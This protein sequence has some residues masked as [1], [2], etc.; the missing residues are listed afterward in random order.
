LF[1]VEEGQ[2]FV[3]L[4]DASAVLALGE[5][6]LHTANQ[7][8][9][10]FCTSIAQRMIEVGV[11]EV[12]RQAHWL[13][14]LQQMSRPAESADRNQLLALATGSLLSIVP[15]FSVDAV[16]TT[17]I[18][19]IARTVGHGSLEDEGLA[20]ARERARRNPDVPSMAA[21]LAHVRGLIN[22]DSREFA[23]AA[24]GFASVARPLAQASALE[25]LGRAL[26]LQGH[27]TDGVEQ[28]SRSLQTYSDC[29]ATWDAGR[30]RGRLRA[31][32]VR[33]RLARPA[34]PS[35][36]RDG[37]TE[38]ERKVADLVGQGLTNR[39]V[40]ERLF[41]SPHTASMHLRHVFA[42][43]GI[44]SRIELIRIASAGEPADD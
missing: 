41:V 25:D 38:S 39:E 17:R 7:A 27:R 23:D 32:G 13:L 31:L 42:K 24:A 10:R 3:T 14:A 2:E 20:L 21:A 34:T 30:V 15:T 12:R 4:L 11:P 26:A 33:R 1:A 22:E 35:G 28:L 18:I 36:A 5:A 40:A 6:A 29:G 37:L 43:L 8:Q 16:D 44:N 19:R 9:S